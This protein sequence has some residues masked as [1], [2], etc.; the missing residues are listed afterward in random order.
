MSN[1]EFIFVPEG[2]QHVVVPINESDGKQLQDIANGYRS[3]IE[4]NLQSHDGTN[5]ILY[6]INEKDLEADETIKYDG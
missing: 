6:F 1:E 5:I 4:W 3:S 2:E